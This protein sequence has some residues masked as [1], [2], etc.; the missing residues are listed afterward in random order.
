[1]PA[2]ISA[3][4]AGFI[5]TAGVVLLMWGT[6]YFGPTKRQER[7]EAKNEET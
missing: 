1:M 4:L 5:T 6:S 7:R 3:A 2:D